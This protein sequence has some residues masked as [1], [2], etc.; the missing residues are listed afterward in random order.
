MSDNAVLYWFDPADDHPHGSTEW[1]RRYAR[2]VKAAARAID[3]TA[4][5]FAD[6]PCVWIRTGSVN[7]HPRMR[8]EHRRL[9]VEC[10]VFDSPDATVAASIRSALEKVDSTWKI[11]VTGPDERALAVLPVIA[12]LVSGVYVE[13]SSWTGRANEADWER[14]LGLPVVARDHYEDLPD[15]A[16]HGGTSRAYPGLITVLARALARRA[17]PQSGETPSASSDESGDAR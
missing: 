5:A 2:A 14:L 17:V 9:T 13:T 11:A 6:V 16:D 12:A 1:N 15:L 8:D 4:E 7:G 3:W 10:V